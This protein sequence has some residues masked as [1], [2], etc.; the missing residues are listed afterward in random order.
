MLCQSVRERD[1]TL[2][3][4]VALDL[5][6]HGMRLRSTRRVL[7]GELVLV[8]FFEPHAARWFDVSAT[9]ARVVHGRRAGDDE[10]SVALEFHGLAAADRARLAAAVAA[11]PDLPHGQGN[12]GS[13]RPRRR[14]PASV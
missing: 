8:S 7:T 14:A 6:A 9:V 5:S 3:G 10:R 1:F 11:R 4:E 13:R 2:L 12:A